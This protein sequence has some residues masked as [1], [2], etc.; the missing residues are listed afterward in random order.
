M[1]SINLYRRVRMHAR[2]TLVNQPI[3]RS[4]IPPGYTLSNKKNETIHEAKK[5]GNGIPGV[6]PP[7]TIPPPRYYTT[8]YSPQ[9]QRNILPVVVQ[10]FVVPNS[11]V[12]LSMWLTCGALVALVALALIPLKSLGKFPVSFILCIRTEDPRWGLRL[13]GPGF[14][15]SAR[16]RSPIQ[17]L[18]V[19]V[20][21]L[22]FHRIYILGPSLLIGFRVCWNWSSPVP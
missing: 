22:A 3:T 10:T 1:L 14:G 9:L 5:T 13:L 8:I 7:A 17:R 11:R 4:I 12:L 18:P 21:T 16:S 20:K 6:L 15:S 19:L 2:F